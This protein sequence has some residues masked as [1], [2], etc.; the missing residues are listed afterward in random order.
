M[1]EKIEP[2]LKVYYMVFLLP[3]SIVAFISGIFISVS[4][5]IITSSIPEGLSKIGGL[6]I[7]S[8]IT[9]FLASV[10]TMVWTV[11]IKDALDRYTHYRSEERKKHREARLKDDWYDFIN[12]I[13]EKEDRKKRLC[14]L[15]ISFFTTVL[16]VVSSLVLWIIA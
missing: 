13:G 9:M 2:L 12:S 5:N 4:T 15:N 7:A 14:I 16:L 11:S 6:Y 1:L 10:S 3:D 8:S